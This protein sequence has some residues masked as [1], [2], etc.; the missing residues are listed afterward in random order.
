MAAWLAAGIIE[1]RLGEQIE[2]GLV[3]G[4][5][6]EASRLDHAISGYENQAAHLASDYHMR[7]FVGKVHQ[8]RAGSLEPG[9][10]IGGIDKFDQIDPGSALPLSQLAARLS[11]KAQ[12]I[13]ASVLELNIKDVY[14]NDLGRTAGF[15]WD[16]P[17]NK[18]IV[19][20]SMKSGKTLIGNA[21]RAAPK[22]DRV[23]LV[24][25][26]TA[27][28]GDLVGALVVEMALEPLVGALSAHRSYG[29]TTEAHIAQ[30]MPLGG[31]QFITP[32]RFQP[33]AAFKVVIPKND[34]TP[35]HMAFKAT[36]PK[37]VQLPD[38]RG[39]ASILAIQTVGKTGWGLVVKKDHAAA[40]APVTEVQY[41]LE[42]ACLIA[43]IALLLGWWVFL[44]PLSERLG[45]AAQ[46]A[47][48]IASGDYASP[49]GDTESDEIGDMSR[50]IDRLA[51]DLDAGN[52]L[53]SRAEV[54]LQFQATRDALTGVYNRKYI[55]ELINKH[56]DPNAEIVSSVLF[57]DLDGFKA[58][59]DGYGHAVGDEILRAVAQRLKSSLGDAEIA[60]WGGDEFVVL[61]PGI[62]GKPVKEIAEFV[63]SVISTPIS[64]SQG[65][66]RIDT[67]VGVASSSPKLSA[68]EVLNRADQHMFAEKQ[69]RVSR[70]GS[71]E[72][73]RIVEA[74]LKANQVE[75][76]FQPIVAV[77]SDTRSLVGAEALVRLRG[78]DKVIT[79][80]E[81]LS[82]IESTPISRSLDRRVA[83]Q[84]IA[85]LGV[86]RQQGIV[87][88]DFRIAINLSA[89]A[90]ND[91]SFFE[92]L[93]KAWTKAQVPP[94]NIIL[95]MSQ[96]TDELNSEVLQL[97][98]Q[99]GVL[100]AADDVGTSNS[101]LD[102]LAWGG[103]RLAKVD[104]SWLSESSDSEKT[105][106]RSVVLPH[107]VQICAE[108]GIGVIAEGVETDEQLERLRK[109]GVRW[110]Q[111][112]HIDIPRT[113]ADFAK[114][115]A[116]DTLSP[117]APSA[118]ANADADV[119]AQ[120][121]SVKQNKKSAKT[122]ESKLTKTATK[123]ATKNSE[124]PA[125]AK[126]GKAKQRSK[127]GITEA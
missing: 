36:D 111:G 37:I 72:G 121:S 19:Q 23:G 12:S 13:G 122:R 68:N 81:F 109:M 35:I 73:A 2:R 17:F 45:N 67:S 107:I 120:D 93:D 124:K 100:L 3:N 48:R 8:Y 66:Q 85:T 53:R 52:K 105:N 98:L 126:A 22:D 16:K 83:E 114:R 103:I 32:L 76:W 80:A 7:D 69:T 40:F 61:L 59:N 57:L 119:S 38:Y 113:P 41:V 117:S 102:R 47:E 62:S 99:K 71:S 78:K 33:D 43:G 18:N 34:A 116:I 49:I 95:E 6:L 21:F 54:K 97:Y 56:L 104:R 10:P 101:N 84:A 89:R 26:I 91:V 65:K 64:T 82:D 115:W 74:A 31:A 30:P 112:F 11:V 29:K 92:M 86:W 70:S 79:P 106:S 15:S 27:F 14:G 5:R 58:I 125:A 90:S 46:A 110:V 75:T 51:T 60:R 118:K 25:P 127:K 88:Q 55:T 108:L 96:A 94:E 1:T 9:T 77:S 28:N 24:T 4:L 123:S 44:R 20:D 50:S 63:R 42:L 87:D 39:E